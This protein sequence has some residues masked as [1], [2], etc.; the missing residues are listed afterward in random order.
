MTENRPLT[1]REMRERERAE[2]ARRQAEQAGANPAPEEVSEAQPP[3]A[4]P[5]P[6][7][8][9]A[10]P[11]PAPPVAAQP[12]VSPAA[13]A[14]EPAPGP[15]EPTQPVASPEPPAAPRRTSMADRM[16]GAPRPP[17]RRELRARMIASTPDEA[18]TA[19][20]EALRRPV[21]EPTTTTGMSVVDHTGSVTAVN[22]P[23]TDDEPASPATPDHAESAPSPEQPASPDVPSAATPSPSGADSADLAGTEATAEASFDE[24]FE[25]L[26][27]EVTEPVQPARKSVFTS[28]RP[29]EEAA[30]AE[31]PAPAPAPAVDEQEPAEEAVRPRR[32]WFALPYL[33]QLLIVIVAMFIVGVVIWLVLDRTMSDPAEALGFPIIEGFL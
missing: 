27:D 21:Q 6:P 23:V 14:P 3:A 8:A 25:G 28:V 30:V 7:A 20:R 18:S 19:A 32:G 5:P 17:S 16:E 9:A 1:R 29:A 10:S 2:E 11:P 13:E 31:T 4:P 12:A 22:I 24:L 15:P 26:D 33:V